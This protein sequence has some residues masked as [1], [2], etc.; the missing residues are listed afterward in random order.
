MSRL[1]SARASLAKAQQDLADEE[2]RLREAIARAQA[3]LEPA[4]RELTA[5][6]E[7]WRHDRDRSHNDLMPELAAGWQSETWDRWE[8]KG[9]PLD[10]IRIGEIRDDN[11]P[12]SAAL[13]PFAGSHRPIVL[14][15]RGPEAADTARA[16][17]RSIAVRSALLL[18]HRARFHLVDP[19]LEGRTFPMSGQLPEVAPRSG[20]VSTDL[21]LLF[22]DCARITETYPET[23]FD[24]LPEDLRAYEKFNVVLAADF[25][26]QYDSRAVQALH[27]VERYAMAGAILVMH[28]DLDADKPGEY[29]DLNLTNPY[30]LDIQ[31]GHTPINWHGLEGVLVPDAEPSVELTRR[32]LELIN[33]TKPAEPTVRWSELNTTDPANWWKESSDERVTATF[34][35]AA[36]T[37]GTLDLT[38]GIDDHGQAKSHTA[39]AGMTGAG[40]SVMFH[41]LILGLATRY[42]PDELALYL[43][44]GKAGSEFQLH[45]E[46]PHAKVVSLQTA[47]EL[48]RSVVLELVDEMKRRYALFQA[49]GGDVKIQDFSSYRARGESLPRVVLVVDEYQS[50]FEEDPDD[51]ASAAILQLAQQGRAAGIH[52]YFASQGFKAKGLRHA[53]EVFQNVHSRI[54]LQLEDS[55][56]D[57][58]SEFAADGRAL[59]KTHN[60][61][62]GRVVVNTNAGAAGVS[63]A[64]KVALLLPEEVA[65]LIA[66]LRAKAMGEGYGSREPLLFNSKEQPRAKE[67]TALRTLAHQEDRSP[68]ALEAVAKRPV[69]EG[70]FGRPGWLA[71]DRPL[72]AVLGRELTVSGNAIAALERRAGENLLFVGANL[73][74]VVGTI[75]TAMWSSTRANPTGSL[76][77]ALLN[78]PT[79]GGSWDAVLGQPLRDLLALERAEEIQGDP[80]EQ[81]RII[82]AE[83]ERRLLLNDEERVRLSPILVVGIELDRRSVFLQ[84]HDDYVL[85]PSDQGR[86]LLRL[87]ESGPAVGIHCLL[88]FR[89]VSSLNAVLPER[90]ISRFRHRAFLQISEDDSFTLLG[91]S[92]GAKVQPK[93]EPIPVRAGYLDTQE[94]STQTFLPFTTAATAE[95]GTPLL[96][97]DLNYLAT[98]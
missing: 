53:Y 41:S 37:T 31:A 72:P 34:G 44:D 71:V 50:L 2:S 98:R 4:R 26:R 51:S 29:D 42:S 27:R 62:I 38:F 32:L 45:Q 69:H 93:G 86:Q 47:P 18:G 48:A 75:A 83:L 95:D 46:L 91:T 12:V 57:A 10:H 63:R 87:V 17:L 58:L 89:S 52:I 21:D 30:V 6:E 65:D 67:S 76:T 59:I 19:H 77:W 33:A 5:K 7:A 40:K 3:A 81:I 61:H 14:R 94:G 97:A 90:A 88:G 56:V 15:T 13:V 78:A 39:Q 82:V 1:T 25:P 35:R 54:A 84:N 23:P 49:S 74:A 85:E 92:A 9:A 80:T 16:I 60:T 64:G 66:L 8:P 24:R 43:I 11:E 73:E 55:T 79:P 28:Y 20:D 70:G 22:K 36:G 96:V 68:A